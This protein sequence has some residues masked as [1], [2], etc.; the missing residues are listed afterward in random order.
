MTS[1]Y[2]YRYLRDGRLEKLLTY[3]DKAPLELRVARM[4]CLKKM[5][6]IDPDAAAEL[7]PSVRPGKGLSYT[8]THGHV[9]LHTVTSCNTQHTAKERA[10]VY[11]HTRSPTIT[12]RRIP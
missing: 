10:V 9:Q 1:Q 4:E 6:A 8:I 12:Y 5:A 11:N 3:D 2:A 7:V